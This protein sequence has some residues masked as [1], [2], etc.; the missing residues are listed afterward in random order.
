M[1]K[2]NVIDYKCNKMSA[3]ATALFVIAG[4]GISTGSGMIIIS[5]GYATFASEVPNLFWPIWIGCIIITAVSCCLY[6]DKFVQIASRRYGRIA[7]GI[8]MV[9]LFAMLLVSFG[10]EMSVVSKQLSDYLLINIL[11]PLL[12]NVLIGFASAART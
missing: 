7:I 10:T 4:L 11:G 1:R 9:S 8:G 12:F 5:S 3:I 2:I 6:G